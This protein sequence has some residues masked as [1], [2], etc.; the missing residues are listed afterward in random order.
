MLRITD[1]FQSMIPIVVKTRQKENPMTYIIYNKSMVKMNHSPYVVFKNSLEEAE[2][3]F[4]WACEDLNPGEAMFLVKVDI[5]RG[6]LTEEIIKEGMEND[7]KNH[8]VT[9]HKERSNFITDEIDES[10]ED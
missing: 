10:W 2:Q 3:N 8:K 1:V 7:W 5:E 4:S 6:K 9:I